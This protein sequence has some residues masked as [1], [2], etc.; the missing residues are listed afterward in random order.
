[1]LRIDE[2]E[3]GIPLPQLSGTGFGTE[4]AVRAIGALAFETGTKIKWADRVAAAAVGTGF[5]RICELHVARIV[6]LKQHLDQCIGTAF[7]AEVFL[8]VRK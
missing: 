1:M 3:Q 6:G 8:I 4:I 5:F 7:L 2:I